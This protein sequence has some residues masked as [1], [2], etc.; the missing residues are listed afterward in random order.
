MSK[1]AGIPDWVIKRAHEVL[2]QL[3]AGKTVSVPKIRANFVSDSK[4]N[5]QM[6][7]TDPAGDRILERLRGIDE[8]TVSPLE[9]LGILFELKKMM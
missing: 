7:L 6:T 8:N 2:S 3:E 4:D 5:G 9:A 1:L